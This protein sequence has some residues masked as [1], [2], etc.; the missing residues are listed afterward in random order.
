MSVPRGMMDVVVA[1]GL[2]IALIGPSWAMSPRYSYLGRARLVEVEST[3]VL[4]L[5]MV[6][7][8]RV[9]TVRLLGVGSP[10][11]RDRVK[12]LGPQVESF[13]RKNE[14]WQASRSYV[15]SLLASKV[16]EV[17]A[18]KWDQLDDKNRLL[19]YVLIPESQERSLDV[20]AEIIKQGLGFVTRDYTHV[21]FVGYRTLEEEAKKQGRGI[22]AALSRDRLSSLS[23]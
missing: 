10:H 13:I 21:T 20:N 8:N 22:W 7:H 2:C 19:A 15:K 14:L 16:V 9:V 3:N 12:D 17:W 18:R 11:N 5:R 23:P 4:K 6:E 1:V